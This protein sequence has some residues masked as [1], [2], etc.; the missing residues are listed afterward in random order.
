MKPKEH[1]TYIDQALDNAKG[2]SWLDDGRIP[3]ENNDD[4]ES[5]KG[6]DSG[7]D[8]RMRGWGFD[9][10]LNQSCKIRS[11]GRF[12]ANLIVS[13]NAVDDG[14]ERPSS[15]RRAQSDCEYADSIFPKPALD[16][17]ERG[18]QDSGSFS[19]YFSLDSWW[20]EK[21]KDLPESVQRTFPFLVVP[22]AGKKEK[23]LGCEGLSE[24]RSAVEMDVN[25]QCTMANICPKHHITDCPCGWRPSKAKNY[26]PTV[27]PL[28]LMSYLV[29]LGSRPGDL[30]LDPFAGTCTTG[31][32]AKMLGRD[33]LMIEI[34]EE[35]C[36]IGKRRLGAVLI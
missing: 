10:A 9:K 5:A 15:W 13:D 19:R 33:Y 6:G 28:K 16:R 21:L 7:S 34:G 20:S 35:W 24:E 27:K 3:Y 36:Q 8:N 26:H 17:E 29:T 18:H 1:N 14:R 25:K 22:K 2:I 23:N 32:A 12:P 31:M 11:S 4:F 30:I